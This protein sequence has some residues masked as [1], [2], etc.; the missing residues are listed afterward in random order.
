MS[1]WRFGS[2]H[3][4]FQ[5]GDGCRFQ[6]FIFQGV[7]T[8]P[9]KKLTTAASFSFSPEIFPCLKR[10]KIFHFFGAFYFGQALRCFEADVS[11]MECINKG[12]HHLN[13]L[14]ATRLGIW[15]NLRFQGAPWYFWVWYS[16][17]GFC[18]FL[19]LW[20]MMQVSNFAGPKMGSPKTVIVGILDINNRHLCF[21]KWY[22]PPQFLRY[23]QSDTL[24]VVF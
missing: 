24:D 13:K 11:F 14:M 19:C 5:M 20:F 23:R 6:P 3:F 9:L 16:S 12:S 10:C 7:Y 4:P 8:L 1:S 17:L 18:A 2:D 22:P 15:I 21:P